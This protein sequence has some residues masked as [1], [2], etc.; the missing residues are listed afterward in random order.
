MVYLKAPPPMEYACKP[1][2]NVLS[3][4]WFIYLFLFFQFCDVAKVTSHNHPK[5]NLAKFGY[6]TY[7]EDFILFYFSINFVMLLKW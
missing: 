6:K 3:C 1:S 5:E 2:S 7:M 4:L